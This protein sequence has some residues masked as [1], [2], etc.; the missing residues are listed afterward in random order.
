MFLW[1]LQASF[2]LAQADDILPLTYSTY[3]GGTLAD[4]GHSIALDAAGRIYVVGMSQSTDFPTGTLPLAPEHGIDSYVARFA[5]D[6]RTLEYV[7]W[8]NAQAQNQ[9][10]EA[11][12][13]AVDASGA[14]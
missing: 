9:I 11:Y 14:A 5:P 10:D 1:R 13:L 8:F 7:Y 2:T 3:L 6:G 12:G 4:A